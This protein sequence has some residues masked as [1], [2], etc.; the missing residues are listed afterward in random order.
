MLEKNN[1]EYMIFY[2]DDGEFDNSKFNFNATAV[3]FKKNT[4][5]KFLKT[6]KLLSIV[7]V[8]LFFLKILKNKNKF[9]YSKIVGVDS[10]GYI[11]SRVFYKKVIY[12]SL[13]VSKSRLNSLIFSNFL[14]E[15]LIIQ[16][17]TRL[18]YLADDFSEVMLIQN[19][20]ILYGSKFNEKI[21]TGKLLYL[22]NIVKEH[23]IE[24]CIEAL[25]LMREETLYIKGVGDPSYIDFLK[26]KYKKLYLNNR[27]VIDD[28]YVNQSD[29]YGFLKNFDVGFCL[30]DFNEIGVNFNYQSSPSGKMFNYFMASMPVIG[31]NIIGLNVV[32]EHN[33]GVLLDKICLEDIVNAVSLI[34]NDYVTLSSN[35]YVVACRYDYEK[36]F[37]SNWDRLAR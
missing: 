23:G 33:A 34:K 21:Y 22:G 9:E 35:A 18:N 8:I 26:E 7:K 30:Y 32:N 2:F 24:I 17:T 5:F 29:L 28:V 1:Q 36:M 12:Y 25:D 31:N 15:L 13:E 20:P 37:M 27:F 10:L 11:I 6:M 4:Y 16:S 19:S 14:P 3:K